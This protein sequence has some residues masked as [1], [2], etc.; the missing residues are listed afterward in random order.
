MDRTER[1]LSRQRV[2]RARNTAGGAP[3]DQKSFRSD[4]GFST[5]DAGYDQLQEQIT[6]FDTEY[7][8]IS[9]E[10]DE[11]SAKID[12][13]VRDVGSNT[14]QAA[15]DVAQDDYILVTLENGVMTAQERAEKEAEAIR[16]ATIDEGLGSAAATAATGRQAW[17]FGVVG[18]TGNA[19]SAL[20]GSNPSGG[21]PASGPAVSDYL[22]DYEV[23]KGGDAQGRAFFRLPAAAIEKLH[24]TSFN[25]GSGSY[26]GHW[27]DINGKVVNS[28]K[29]GGVTYSIDAEPVGIDPEAYRDVGR[30]LM[31]AEDRVKADFFIAAQSSLGAENRG[32]MENLNMQRGVLEGERD[33]LVTA[34]E[35][36]DARLA[37]LKTDY[38]TNQTARQG[39]YTSD[40]TR[41]S[42][43]TSDAPQTALSGIRNK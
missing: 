29:E 20:G 25:Q 15:W 21:G 34:K 5:T 33:I 18:S 37:S 38:E 14:I 10:L 43:N 12:E 11:Y 28:Q 9:N 40:S 31:I 26:E 32:Y 8:R 36:R 35:D 2:R 24:T 7:G 17:D 23:R 4:L 27:F 19:S 30:Q 39:S 41:R 3:I 13:G 6:G 1:I 42:V 22:T 16:R